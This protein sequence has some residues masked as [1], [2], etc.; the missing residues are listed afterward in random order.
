[1]EEAK[2]VLDSL[3]PIVRRCTIGNVSADGFFLI[4]VRAAFAKNYEINRFL[5]TREAA[6]N[7]FAVTSVLRGMCEDIIALKWL[8]T[9]EKRDRD[10][11]VGVMM[12]KSVLEQMQQQT[13]FFGKYR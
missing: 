9:F 5:Q 13:A 12:M 11:A 1:M 3:E 10:E 4:S 2:P 6:M 8:G 7:A